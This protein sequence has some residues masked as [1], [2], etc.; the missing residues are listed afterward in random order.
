[1][2][3]AVCYGEG[4][5]LVVEEVT[6]PSPGEGEVKVRVGACA[7]CQSDLHYLSGAWPGKPFP[8]VCGHEVAGTV[9]AAGRAV[10]S[11][12]EGDRVIVSLIRDCGTCRYCASGHPYLC[13]TLLPIDSGERFR[14]P[15]GQRVYQGLRVGGFADHVVVHQSQLAA[16][17]DDMPFDQASLLACGV[18]TG[19]GAVANAA[20]M[21]PGASVAVIGIGGVGIN[22]LQAAA[23]G[24]A[25][26][27]IAI[28][29][30]PEK[31]A[32]ARKLGATHTLDPKDTAVV[33]AVLELTGGF[34]VD[35]VFVAAGS[36]AAIEQGAE[37]LSKLGCMVVAALPPAG[38]SAQIEPRFL[39]NKNQTFMGSK[40]GSAR[41]TVDVPKL[42]EHY[43]EG[44][45]ELAALI[46]G[47][48]P[49]AGINDAMA[50]AGRGAAA[51]N[52]ITFDH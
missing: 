39:V 5:P 23:I 33:E 18:L 30:V 14:D 41:L 7:I 40:M 13:E 10:E 20:R 35:Y 45:L 29:R 42:L 36:G 50:T 34:G 1:M 21:R 46:G 16:I 2:K 9:V 47:H 44:R 12:R 48:Y 6:C 4:Q 52:V 31:F 19:Y 11:A 17:P 24:R 25:E 28:D 27:L 43:R 15:Q 22:C 49:L 8:A 37:I 3:A 38:V 51:R 32:L 26:T